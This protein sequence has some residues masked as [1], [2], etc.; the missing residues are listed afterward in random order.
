MTINELIAQLETIRAEYGDIEVLQDA[1]MDEIVG[2]GYANVRIAE[3][4]EFPDD[5]NMPEGFTFVELGR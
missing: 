2:I 4:G 5:W 3:D 1:N